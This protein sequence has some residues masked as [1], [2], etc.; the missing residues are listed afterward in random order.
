[1]IIGAQKCGTTALHSY[2]SRHPQISM[3]RPKEV[4][5]F[6]TGA[7]WERG[8]DWYRDRFDASAPVRGESSPN[9]TADPAIA[10][11]PARMAELIPDAK[12]IYM[13]RDPIDRV[14]AN[15]VH[16]YSNRAED[17]PLRDAVLDPESSY[18]ARSR[19]H[20]QLSRYLEHYPLDGVL[21][22]EQGDLLGD[23]RETLR[24]VFGFLEVDEDVWHDAFDVQRLETSARRRRT[25]LGAF[26]AERVRLRVWRRL[27]DHRPFSTAFEHP[28]IDADLR[29]RLTELLADDVARFRE[30]TGR[31]FASWSL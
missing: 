2:L 15:W 5:F 14:R 23:R 19:Y 28:E 30:L 20:H 9:Y 26:V 21:V 13:V 31:K 6:I 4:D 29:A 10:G 22:L 8:V 17:R 1:V 16:T 11:V 3:S 27:R 7:N 25:P 24:R 12:L 18:V